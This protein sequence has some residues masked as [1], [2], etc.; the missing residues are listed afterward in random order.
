MSNFTD[1]RRA[2]GNISGPGGP[3]DR[4]A[5]VIDTQYAVLLDY[6]E[7]ALVEVHHGEEKGPAL[8]LMLAGRINKTTERSQVVYLFDTDGA[9]A[10][11]SQLIGLASRMG[12][13]FLEDLTRRLR[14]LP[15]RE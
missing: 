11:I 6:T 15:V 1:P 8:A 14:E 10:I 3:F 2:G 5:V 12:Q 7:V 13:E 9:A 4:N